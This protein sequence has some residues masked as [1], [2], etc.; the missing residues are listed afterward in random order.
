MLDSSGMCTSK[1]LI[2]LH[3]GGRG[4]RGRP[5]KKRNHKNHGLNPAARERRVNRQGGCTCDANFG[6]SSKKHR[7][8]AMQPPP[9][10]PPPKSPSFLPVHKEEDCSVD[11]AGAIVRARTGHGQRTTCLSLSLSFLPIYGTRVFEDFEERALVKNKRTSLVT[12]T[13]SFIISVS[14]RFDGDM[15]N[16]FFALGGK[17]SPWT[18]RGGAVRVEAWWFGGEKKQQGVRR[19]AIRERVQQA[20]QPAINLPL[21]YPRINQTRRENRTPHPYSRERAC[22][23][24]TSAGVPVPLRATVASEIQTYLASVEKS[25]L[26]R[27]HLLLYFLVFALFSVRGR[28][29]TARQTDS[30]RARRGWQIPR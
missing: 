20:H 16:I 27:K 15:D 3:I 5:K 25:L 24:E 9:P 10:P 21:V 13:H 8:E 2:I 14:R 23:G 26:L 18:C 12:R 7:Q 11:W 30:G 28:E 22:P 19:S 4:G 17:W 6:A 29:C 1:S